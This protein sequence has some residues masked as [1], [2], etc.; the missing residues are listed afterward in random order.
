M[1][2]PLLAAAALLALLGCNS[3]PQEAG[4]VLF[5]VNGKKYTEAELRDLAMALN[6]T[7][8]QGFLSRPDMAAE[9]VNFVVGLA[10][11]QAVLA[12]AKKTGMAE[13]PAYQMLA[14]KAQAQALMQLM[15]TQRVG[16]PSE[17]QLREVYNGFKAQNAKGGNAQGF[18]TQEDAMGNPALRAQ[19]ANAWK[20]KRTQEA[21]QEVMKEIR[22]Q[23]P[24]TFAEGYQPAEQ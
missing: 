13:G 23:V 19:L 3:A 1:R 16:E 6:P 14:A 9:R 10:Q 21:M 7:Q 8:A 22:S 24:M 5:N 11:D 20:Q 15:V 2:T 12:F 18:P 17:D 4:A